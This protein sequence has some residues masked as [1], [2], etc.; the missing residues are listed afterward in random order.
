[1]GD[2]QF[3]HERLLTARLSLQRPTSADIDAIYRIHHD[4]RATAHNPADRLVTRADAEDRYR[5]WDQHWQRHGFGYWVIYPRDAH[6]PRLSLGFCGL[7][8]MRLVNRE[9]LNLLYRLDPAIWGNRVATEAAAAV[10]D[11][12]AAHQQERPV[13]A[14][15]RPDNIASARVAARIGMHRAEH[16]DTYG[17]DGLDWVF[18]KNWPEG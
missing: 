18:T 5:R 2:H 11:W 12:A 1:M 14:R 9:V 17:E 6:E 8:L 16:L 7:K 10:V 13:V 15:I 4:A 3:D